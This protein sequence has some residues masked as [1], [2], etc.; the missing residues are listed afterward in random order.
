MECYGTSPTFCHMHK[1]CLDLVPWR[2][3]FFYVCV[4]DS[5][6]QGHLRMGSEAHT[7]GKGKVSERVGGA[8]ARTHTHSERGVEKRRRAGEGPTPSTTRPW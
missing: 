3:L 1:I 8:R 6:H 7:A 4:Y 2:M 5:Y